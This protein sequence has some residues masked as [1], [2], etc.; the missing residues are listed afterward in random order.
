MLRDL[1]Q[2]LGL[3]GLVRALEPAVARSAAPERARLLSADVLSTAAAAAPALLRQL[4]HGRPQTMVR[5]LA[6]LLGAAP[7]FAPFFVRRPESF[8]RLCA[9]D[10][11]KARTPAEYGLR[12]R[13]ATAHSNQHEVGNDL[14]RFKYYE[15][16]R[17]TVRDLSPDLAPA[18]E[19]PVILK[20]LSWLAD[21]LLARALDAA[22]DTLV[23]S[24]GPPQWRNSNGDEIALRFCVLALGKLGG[25]ELNYSSD[26]DLVYVFE[27]PPGTVIPESG[28]KELSPVEYF[29]RLA[30][31]F[32]RLV[33][34]V[35]AEGFL[36]RIDLDLRPEGSRGQLVVSD[37]MLA[38]Y[39]ELWAAT[40]ERAVFMKARPVA[41]DLAFGWQVVRSID[42][43]IYRSSMDLAAVAAI[44]E[45]KER[46]ER[47]KDQ[48]GE[49][50]DVKIGP[51]GIRDIE[52]VA[53]ALQLL[54]GG[55]FP[56][57][58]GRSTQRALR[59]LSEVGM[60]GRE[61]AD[62]LLD[63]YGFL[64]RTENR[65]QM[66][67]EQRVHRLPRETGARGRLARA[68][69]FLGDGAVA[70]FE[71]EL[72]R[73][74]RQV[75]EIF[76][77]LFHRGSS[78]RIMEIFT[79]RVPALVNDPVLGP[80]MENLAHQ[81]A[82][83][84][85]A[86]AN[87]ERALSNFERFTEAIRTRRFYYEL[88]LDRPELV[89]RLTALFASSEYL[90]HYLATHPR[91]IE[92]I[93]DDPNVLILTRTQLREAFT[94]IRANLVAEGRHDEVE[95]E[96]DA[97]RLF[98]N[99]ELVNVGLLDLDGKVPLAEVER[100][101]TEIAEV[102][103]EQ[104]L[105]V[106]LNEMR[107]RAPQHADL[108]E[109]GS[110]LVVG[111]GKLGSYEIT[112]GSDL[113]VIFLYDVEEPDEDRLLQA[114][115]FFVRLAQKLIWALRTRTTEGVC[116]DI[117]PRLRPSGNQGMLVSPLT[118][119]ARYHADSAAV[120]ERQTLLRARPVAGA[121]RLGK[122]F[123]KLRREILRGPLPG[124]LRAEIHRIRLRME[125]ELAHED[126]RRRDFKTGRGGLTDV[127]SV[128][129]CL[130]LQHCGEHEELIEVTPLAVQI[131]RLRTLGLLRSD[132]AEILRQGWE[133]LRR[134]GSRLRIIANRS[135]SDLDA[136]RGD[137]DALA[138]QLGYSAPQRTGGARRALLEDYRAHTTG[139]RAV[140]AS[141]FETA[142]N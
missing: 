26:V 67:A 42:P 141:V 2:R 23:V 44:R 10:L 59:A 125:R 72:E 14:R 55:R 116:Y 108:A 140:Y 11:T 39:Y 1:E 91:L 35:T 34:D 74:R 81:F 121:R 117:D 64:R 89:P 100:G 103:I 101:L 96:L 120:W 43:M 107:K 25:E 132:Q 8:L 93:F 71:Q 80:M 15:L 86:S 58:R 3:S 12:L 38:S 40:W 127:E 53:Q 6:N 77:A 110:F 112:Y 30:Q 137:L 129:Q 22:A 13:E 45:L 115:E 27:A 134:L 111:M 17:I 104:A 60:L 78:E 48:G 102:C 7:F 95:L 33:T 50:F 52:F 5:I 118:Q 128:V 114:Q 73:H 54:H 37:E 76:A 46:V 85:D 29:T 88:L 84:I 56:Q 83:E 82:H 136:E 61:E 109:E 63:A 51:G 62:A 139:I 41:G 4:W 138:R 21:A 142:T 66:E 106:A 98:H 36:Y 123:E 28:P 79:T 32:G 113:D 49:P 97:L 9:E 24:H 131:E 75:R 130:Q 70:A 105:A 90:S 19:T 31:A 16:A 126:A 99:R 124:N 18:P 68:M 65:L 133:F 87:P 57:V 94:R 69:G 135:I 20:E 122:A 47:R 92:P 119:F